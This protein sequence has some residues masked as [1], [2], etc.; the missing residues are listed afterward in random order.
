MASKRIIHNKTKATG[1]LIGN[2]IDNRNI[3]QKI[4]NGIMQNQL[5]IKIITKYLRKG[6]FFQKK[7]IKLL[8]I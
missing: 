2:K 1:D 3:S 5:Q 7:D 6:I 8:M 4:Y